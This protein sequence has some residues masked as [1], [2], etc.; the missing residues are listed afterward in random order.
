MRRREESGET[1]IETVVATALLGIV[2]IGIIGA[3]ASVL[4][5][6][7]I[8]RRI[9]RGETVLRSY[10]AAI[11]ASP[12]RA[13]AGSG[14]YPETYT[15]PTGFDASI[16]GVEYWDGTGPKAVPGSGVLPFGASCGQDHG[17]QRITVTV[18]SSGARSTTESAT[19]VK[20]GTVPATP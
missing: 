17:L 18:T 2:G 4:I 9:S 7:D 8:D 15:R 19:F 6:T 16:T 20:R 10:V 1:L 3:I 5:S 11:Q 13:C 14:A 12:Y